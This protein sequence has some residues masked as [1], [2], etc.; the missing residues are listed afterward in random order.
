MLP[1][2]VIVIE[3]S[4]MGVIDTGDSPDG[5]IDTGSSPIDD[6]DTGDSPEVAVD[7]VSTLTTESHSCSVR[8]TPAA[9]ISASEAAE[10]VSTGTK[11]YQGVKTKKKETYR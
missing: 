7:E 8:Q 3:D 6:M 1:D 4:S 9:A 5:V 11:G 10:P 2:D